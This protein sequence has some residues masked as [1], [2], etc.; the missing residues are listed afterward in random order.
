MQPCALT[1]QNEHNGSDSPSKQTSQNDRNDP[2]V[3]SNAFTLQKEHN[4]SDSASHRFTIQNEPDGSVLG[5]NH[6]LKN[7]FVLKKLI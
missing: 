7:N 3:E 4:G 1:L 2:I 5:K 6:Q